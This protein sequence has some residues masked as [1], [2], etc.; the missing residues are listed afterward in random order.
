MSEST[1]VLPTLPQLEKVG[2]ESVSKLGVLDYELRVLQARSAEIGD[3]MAQIESQKQELV[4]V[5]KRIESTIKVVKEKAAAGEA[6][7]D[8]SSSEG[9]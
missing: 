9:A 8:A 2:Q 3:R 4:N 7:G 1:P 6:H 5:I